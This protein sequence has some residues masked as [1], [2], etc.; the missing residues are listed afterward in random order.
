MFVGLILQL[1]RELYSHHLLKN[2]SKYVNKQLPKFV[3]GS[4][5]AVN[6]TKANADTATWN[7]GWNFLGPSTLETLNVK[8]QKALRQKI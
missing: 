5:T 8:C 1:E 6:I 4:K 2:S 7:T 3:S